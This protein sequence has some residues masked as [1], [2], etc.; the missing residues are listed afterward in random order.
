MSMTIELIR[1]DAIDHVLV[2]IVLLDA[3][4]HIEG[5]IVGHIVDLGQGDVLVA[6]EQD[7]TLDLIVLD[8]GRG[9]LTPRAGLGKNY[10]LKK[11]PGREHAGNHI[12]GRDLGPNRAESLREKR[13]VRDQNLGVSLGKSQSIVQH[14]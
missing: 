3:V 6:E 7:L 14:S 9:S 13:K 5:L 4:A 2:L 11:G 8:R 12:L 10:D 1:E